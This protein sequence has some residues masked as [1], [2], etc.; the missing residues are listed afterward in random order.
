M[1]LWEN[2]HF[3]GWPVSMAILSYQPNFL[4]FMLWEIAPLRGQMNQW[5][6]F[7][8]HARETLLFNHGKLMKMAESRPTWA[9]I[10]VSFRATFKRHFFQGCIFVSEEN[11]RKSRF[12]CHPKCTQ[13]LQQPSNGT[14]SCDYTARRWRLEPSKVSFSIFALHIGDAR[15]SF[16]SWPSQVFI[17]LAQL[18]I[19]WFKQ[20]HKPA[21]W[22]WSP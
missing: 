13:R 22:E 6:D 2:G 15:G 19:M 20:C 3:L 4:Q 18:P 10:S 5:L 7:S 8:G 1:A 12:C 21:I 14:G 17:D 11:G 16:V 9:K